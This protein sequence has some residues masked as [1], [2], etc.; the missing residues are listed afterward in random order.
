[1]IDLEDWLNASLHPCVVRW[2]PHLNDLGASWDTFKRDKTEVINDL[3]SGG[4]PRLAA[5]DIFSIIEEEIRRSEAPLVILWDLE[6][7]QTPAGANCTD[8]TT[9]LKSILATHGNLVQFR[10][11]TV[12]LSSMP[13]NKR[14]E[15][16]LA[17]CDL[18]DIPHSGESEGA[19]NNYIIVDA[20]KFAFT[21]ME[22][23]TICFVT[24]KVDTYLLANIKNPNLRTIMISDGL[25]QSKSLLQAKCDVMINWDTEV[26]QFRPSP[27]PGFNT[28]LQEHAGAIVTCKPTTRVHD[29]KSTFSRAI[30]ME[31]PERN[32]PK[33]FPLNG[34]ETISLPKSDDS[35]N[36]TDEISDD[37]IKLLRSVVISNAHVGHDGPGTLKC[38]VG[39]LLRS[40]YSSQFPDRTSIQ[41]FLNKACDQNVIVETSN[42]GGAKLLHLPEDIDNT[43]HPTIHLALSLPLPYNSI[44][45]NQRVKDVSSALPIIIFLQK[46]KVPQGSE[47]PVKTFIQSVD[48]FMVLM[49]RSVN[50]AQRAATSKPWILQNASAVVDWRKVGDSPV[51][52]GSTPIFSVETFKCHLCAG[53]FPQV[54]LFVEPGT[55]EHMCRFCFTSSK[56]WTAAER[57]RGIEKVI[58]MLYDMEENDDV[59]VRS[60]LLRRL[61]VERWPDECA[62]RGQAALWIE[63]AVREGTVKEVKEKLTS[64]KKVK[65]V[66]LT[67]NFRW[68]VETHPEVPT[69]LEEKYVNNLLWERGP[70]PRK[71]I[72]N[73]VKGSFP[74]MSCPLM[75]NRMFMNATENGSFV[76]AKGPYDQVVAL[77]QADA[78]AALEKLDDARE[79]SSRGQDNDLASIGSETFD[80][81][82]FLFTS[83]RR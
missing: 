1:M 63:E 66:C 54:E 44:M 40:T 21:N 42:V 41:S 69:L 74:R 38:Q 49:Y 57:S 34:Y 36:R 19:V 58:C 37:E 22:R 26:L 39:S 18:V 8:V 52:G 16:Q 10:G 65:V 59:Y 78:A 2:T 64:S 48:K 9:R 27:P 28:S 32:N 31:I 43:V 13:Q 12:G 60:S 4:V 83:S 68:V 75:R 23:A 33:V 47:F 53:K 7:M 15:L 72:I 29:H 56:S 50:D 51:R 11:Y 30:G 71:E 67:Q 82:R 6:L 35:T 45:A 24:S 46:C 70:C 5:R 62:S 79:N 81:E 25:S 55:I 17:G 73:S 77:S 61:I 76:V 80:L 20:M 14:T 3:V